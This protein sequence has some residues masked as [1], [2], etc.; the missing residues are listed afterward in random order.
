MLF[1]ASIE[2]ISRT[3]QLHYFLYGRVFWYSYFC[4]NIPY[5]V[6]NYVRLYLDMHCIFGF[7]SC[8]TLCLSK[9]P[10]RLTLYCCDLPKVPVSLLLHQTVKTW[11]LMCFVFFLDSFPFVSKQRCTL[12]NTFYHCGRSTM[13]KEVITILHC[14]IRLWIIWSLCPLVNR[15]ACV[16]KIWWG[17]KWSRLVVLLSAIFIILGDNSNLPI[18]VSNSSTQM[19]LHHFSSCKQATALYFLSASPSVTIIRSTTNKNWLKQNWNDN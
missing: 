15:L 9:H 4:F 13:S 7:F 12:E 3:L 6:P 2:K 5:K 16:A 18:S 17:L 14:Y 19:T 1:S 10:V 8:T 11:P